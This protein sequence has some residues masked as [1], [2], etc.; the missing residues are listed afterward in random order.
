MVVLPK[1]R[2][3]WKISYPIMLG[4]V[5]QNVINVTDTAFL[6]RLGEV[7]LG[8]SAIAGLFYISLFMLGF[9]FG[10]GVQ[11]LIARRYGEKRFS[12]IGGIF[13]HGIYFLLLL[14]LV[15]FAIIRFGSPAFMESFIRSDEVRKACNEF[16]HY[17]IYG[18]FFAFINVLIRAFYIGITKTRLIT[19]NAVVMALVNVFL[20]YVLIFGHWG[21]PKMGIAGAA[22]ASVCAEAIAALS[23]L[24]I[25]ARPANIA[26][27]SMFRFRKPDLRIIGNTLQISVYI[28]VQY[29]LSLGGWFIF[30]MI[31]EKMGE[32]PLAV[33]NIIRSAY[34]VMMLP[35]W[36]LS[37][38][39][40]SL[41]SQAIG[42][43][44]PQ[45]VLPLIRKITYLSVTVMSGV[46]LLS[47]L[48]PRF[49]I[50][51]YTGDPGLIADT[52]P[53]L[54]VIMGAMLLFSMAQ[55][56][57][58]GVSGTA[59]TNISMGIEMLTIG[60]YLVFT[61][62][63]GVVFTQEIHI[64]WTSEILYFLLLGIFSYLYLRFGNWKNRKI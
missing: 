18:L 13:D 25:V 51:L 52:L 39:N 15:L 10:T 3:I 47:L 31:I 34:L 42:A 36:A 24:I 55:I 30:F 57:F 60:I 49:I 12:E 7:E 11:I 64:V 6:G 46:I 16:L 53:V 28:M 62:L 56:M 32:R 35:I 4:L 8:A 20:D 23:F 5:A 27:Y 29:F 44:N 26:A 17:R 50:G 21:F 14:A 48:F 37:S 22:I 59:N 38:T 41:V 63:I 33:S 58:S 9:G 19:V 43:G 61:W 2:E 1:Y 54:Y 40:N 45:L